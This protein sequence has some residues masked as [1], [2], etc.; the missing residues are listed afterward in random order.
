[1][2]YSQAEDNHRRLNMALNSEEAKITSADRVKQLYDLE[3]VCL[4]HCH[5]ALNSMPMH[6]TGCRSITLLR[7]TGS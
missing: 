2:S 5:D 6:E 4:R 7:R 1:M 3:Q